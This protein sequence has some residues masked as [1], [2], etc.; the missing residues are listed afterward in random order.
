GGL[1][2]IEDLGKRDPVTDAD[3]IKFLSDFK[4]PV[5]VVT[6]AGAVASVRRLIA[7]VRPQRP[8]AV[9]DKFI[10]GL[11][12][13]LPGS[14]QLTLDLKIRKAHPELWRTKQVNDFLAGI[15]AQSYGIIYLDAIDWFR[16]I[17]WVARII[18]IATAAAA[19]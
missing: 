14:S 12:S 16:R 4:L 5:P 8:F 15:W 2:M 18:C 11:Q 13:Y 7:D 19:V 1:K 6:D 3:I 10:E 9:R 17:Q